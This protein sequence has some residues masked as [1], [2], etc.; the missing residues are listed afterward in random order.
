[1]RGIT[2]PNANVIFNA[3][4]RSPAEDKPKMPIPY[5]YVLWG[6]T[7]YYGWQAVDEA[8]AMIQPTK[9]AGTPPKANIQRQPKRAPM[10]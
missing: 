9:S 5:D 8:I 1:M 4:I 3:Q 10:T 2:F 7:V 6:R